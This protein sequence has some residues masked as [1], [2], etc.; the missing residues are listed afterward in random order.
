LAP[1]RLLGGTHLLEEVI[2]TVLVGRDQAYLNE[3][4][5]SA[6]SIRV[7]STKVGVLDFGISRKEIDALYAKGYSAAEKF[8]L[9]W[10]QEAYIKRFR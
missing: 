3:P 10:D 5:V 6:R 2:A 9:T 7:D 8:L 4:W 1:L